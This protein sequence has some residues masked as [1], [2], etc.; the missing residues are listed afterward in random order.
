MANIY[1]I[2]VAIAVGGNGPQ[3]LSALSRHFLGVNA[4]AAQLTGAMSRLKL[5]VGGALA[6]GGGV[7]LLGVMGKMLHATEDLSREQAKMKAAGLSQLE[8]AHATG[9]AW[10]M[11]TKNAGAAVSENLAAIA[12][13]RAALGNLKDAERV[14]PAYQRNA[15][16]LTSLT[17][18]PGE[19][20]AFQLA[21]AIHLSGRA[22][23]PVTHKLNAE[24][25]SKQMNMYTAMIAAGGGKLQTRDL[26][27]FQ[28]QAGSF[29]TRLSDDGRVNL[30]GAMQ[31][32]GGR[33]AGSRLTA[34]NRALIAGVMPSN[35]M[36]R[37]AD[38]GILDPGQI[39][40]TGKRVTGDAWKADSGAVAGGNVMLG[41]GA[42]RNEQQFIANPA[43][44][45]WG[46]LM[47]LLASKGLTTPGQQVDWV[48]KS[49]LNINSARLIGELISNKYVDLQEAAN[50][51]R[52][53]GVDQYDQVMSTDQKLNRDAM[54]KAWEN[55]ITA[56]ATPLVPMAIGAMQTITKGL[57]AITNW[58]VANPT[59][60]K[61]IGMTLAAVAVGLTVL[62][63]AAVGIAAFALLATGGTVGLVV[64]GISAITAAVG[65][66][67]VLNWEGIKGAAN[68]MGKFVSDVF[69][70]GAYILAH[71]FQA[72]S[73]KAMTGQYLPQTGPGATAAQ[74]NGRTLAWAA[75]NPMGALFKGAK[76]RGGQFV[77]GLEQLAAWGPRN[78]G[79]TPRDALQPPA[80]AANENNRPLV[81]NMDGKK[82]AEI[83]AAHMAQQMG[84]TRQTGRFDPLVGLPSPGAS[85]RQ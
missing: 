16:A 48:N 14:A 20:Q 52:A 65:T 15:I 80:R 7:T 29:G 1:R 25:F 66:L 31:A 26:L 67:V 4:S 42:L 59:A 49:G 50:A 69:A 64:A 32:M 33:Q 46:T 63:V 84:S 41:K 17:G 11:S 61:I 40:A 3:Y 8:V 2:G 47:P 85:Y 79:L 30:I 55:M 13:L 39:R 34:L 24:M 75:A 56:F 45:V 23:D 6:I 57:G 72:Y 68:A 22:N 19:D 82:V 28:Q 78:P 81:I 12:H 21:Q 38:M 70:V 54:A 58:A 83:T 5:A 77:D 73:N 53:G 37:W 44:W 18:R 74:K 62:G 10:Q 35:V 9:R 27:M 36:Q 76:I 43:E 51:R 60:V 71:P